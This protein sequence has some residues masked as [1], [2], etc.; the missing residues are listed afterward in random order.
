MMA[1]LVSSL[2]EPHYIVKLKLQ[3]HHSNIVF[4]FFSKYFHCTM[5]Q[6]L[7]HRGT[8]KQLTSFKT[9]LSPGTDILLFFKRSA[10]IRRDNFF[11]AFETSCIIARKF[12]SFSCLKLLGRTGIHK[13]LDEFETLSYLITHYRVICP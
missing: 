5:E 9:I 4:F 10:C 1:I 11:Y 6:L 8:W 12:G 2:S 7:S 13:S 3:E